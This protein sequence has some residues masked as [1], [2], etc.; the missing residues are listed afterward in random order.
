MFAVS[1]SGV[2]G[3]LHRMRT[4]TFVLGAYLDLW[5]LGMRSCPC[6]VG[7]FWS[8]CAVAG[9]SVGGKEAPDRGILPFVIP[10]DADTKSVGL[11]LDKYWSAVVG[12]IALGPVC[13]P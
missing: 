9:W 3:L 13:A 6:L 2:G 7:V 5:F 12:D 4:W 10:F 11:V 1:Q 8:A